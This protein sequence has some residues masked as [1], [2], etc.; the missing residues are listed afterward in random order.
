MLV[1]SAAGETDYFFEVDLRSPKL[2]GYEVD[3]TLLYL[4]GTGDTQSNGVGPSD[5]ACHRRGKRY[6]KGLTILP[7]SR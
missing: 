4:K 6:Q 5:V 3:H 1:K 7:K 2:L